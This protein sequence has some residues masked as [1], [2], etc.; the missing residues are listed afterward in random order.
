[1]ITARSHGLPLYRDPSVM[2]F[3][4]LRRTPAPADFEHDF[5]ALL[6]GTLADL[7][8]GER[9]LLR[10]VSLFDAFDAGLATQTAGLTHQASA[11][12]LIERPIV[13]E[14]PFGLWPYYLNGLIRSTIRTA[15]DFTDDRWTPVDW[16]RA[17]VRALA[18]LRALGKQ[19]ADGSDHDRPFLASCLR[20]DLTLARD[21]RLDL[22]WL[23]DAA[24]A[25]V[26]D[27][28]WEPIAPPAAR[29]AS[30]GTGRRR[31]PAPSPSC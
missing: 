24:W 9:H 15:D 29:T 11:R 23:T 10:S 27:S 31:R 30:P 25:Y 8:P 17:A 1:M 5:P 19:W 3:L 14:N 13:N 4:E 2:R 22:G 20:Q 7:T 28:V 18:A 12:R 6:A 21:F 26:S 16:E